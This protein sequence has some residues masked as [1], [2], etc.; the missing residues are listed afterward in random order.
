VQGRLAAR[1]TPQNVG[2]R[3]THT[4]HPPLTEAGRRPTSCM[5]EQRF[6][7]FI[8]G[9]ADLRSRLRGASGLTVFSTPCSGGLRITRR[10]AAPGH[11]GPLRTNEVT[12]QGHQPGRPTIDAG[13]PS[14]VCSHTVGASAFVQRL[15]MGLDHPPGCSLA[16]T[17]RRSLTAHRLN[18]LT[19]E[20]HQQRLRAQTR[21]S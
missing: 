2:G 8:V 9:L 19:V 13:T 6:W 18:L 10:K 20:C 15:C 5:E 21:Q 1:P 11:A 16:L 7:R 12:W 4:L 14:V 17:F 3:S